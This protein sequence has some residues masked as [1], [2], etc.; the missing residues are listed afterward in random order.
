MNDTNDTLIN[1]KH[2][3]P[4]SSTRGTSREQLEGTPAQSSRQD[5]A[6]AGGGAVRRRCA[7]LRMSYS[8]GYLIAVARGASFTTH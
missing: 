6:A 2:H 1:I 4:T 3:R 5:A 7:R 8:A